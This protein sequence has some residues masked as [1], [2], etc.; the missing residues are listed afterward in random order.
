MAQRLKRTEGSV[1]DKCRRLGISLRSVRRV[2][3]SREPSSYKHPNAWVE[4]DLDYLRKGVL[5]KTLVELAEELGRSVGSLGNKLREMGISVR[6]TRGYLRG[7]ARPSDRNWSRKD[8]AFLKANA[9]KLTSEEIGEVL[10]KRPKTVRGYASRRGIVLRQ[11]GWSEGDLDLL[12]KYVAEGRSWNDISESLGRG[13][14]AVRAKAR[15]LTLEYK[16]SRWDAQQE[17]A[18]LKAV[19]GGLSWEVLE[20]KF[21]RK[22]RSLQRKYARLKSGG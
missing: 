18:L 14:E 5:K 13:V 9:G 2:N 7:K 15:Y 1:R 21:G 11:G 12:E 4:R 20:E 3:L 10:G 8:I 22:K 16:T 6:K 19:E 17:E